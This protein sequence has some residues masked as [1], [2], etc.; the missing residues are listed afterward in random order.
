MREIL[1]EF[2]KP[3]ED[4]LKKAWDSGIFT[5]DANVLLNLYRYSS[6]TTNELLSTLKHL[7]EKIW[8]TNQAGYEYLNNR[9]AVIHKQK[10][11]YEEVKAILSKKLEEISNE[12]NSYKKHSSIEIDAIKDNIKKSLDKVSADIEKLSKTHPNYETADGIK[13][14]LTSLFNGKTG[15][16]Y[17]KAQLVDLF[18][19]AQHRYDNEIPPGFKDKASKKDAPKQ[20]LYGDVIL[21]KQIIEKAKADKKPIIL[22]TDDL[23]DDWWDK[24]KGETQGPRKELLR[25]FFD[26]TEQGIYIYQADKFLEYANK[27]KIGKIVK[28]EAIKEIRDVRLKDE[29]QLKDYKIA[30]DSLRKYFEEHMKHFQSDDYK[31]I[32]DRLSAQQSLFRLDPETIKRIQENLSKYQSSQLSFND[33]DFFDRYSNLTIFPERR[34]LYR[35]AELLA[36]ERAEEHDNGDKN[37]PMEGHEGDKRDNPKE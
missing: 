29:Q 14:E 13:D 5:F 24:F 17:S 6:K 3:D 35:L 22:V 8:L 18:K 19:E 2:Y 7:H 26:E 1:F 34:T 23:K 11:A 10:V 32:I 21:W 16:P 30:S 9:L 37:S 31:K 25:E 15:S 20:S 4:E 33:R 12:L 36:A 27:L 28:E